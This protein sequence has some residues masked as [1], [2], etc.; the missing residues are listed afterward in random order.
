[1]YSL[2]S[3]AR[4]CCG[5]ACELEKRLR[6]DPCPNPVSPSVYGNSILA[7]GVC[8]T[9]YPRWAV[10]SQCRQLVCHHHWLA[11]CACLSLYIQSYKWIVLYFVTGIIWDA[12]LVA[13][14]PM[15]GSKCHP[16]P[17]HIRCHHMTHG[18]IACV[19]HLP[20]TSSERPV[21]GTYHWLR[22]D[23]HYQSGIYWSHR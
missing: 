12:R 15:D 18:Q 5:W 14:G 22:L 21:T 2:I 1:M 8:S 19:A 9:V 20:L 17:D 4:H 3:L 7:F 13:P 16:L 23:S 11:W 6:C 10:Q